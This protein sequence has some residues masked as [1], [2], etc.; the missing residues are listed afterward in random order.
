DN[1]PLVGF[2][3][4]LTPSSYRFALSLIQ[5]RPPIERL[6]P[7][8]FLMGEKVAKPDEGAAQIRT[9]TPSSVSVST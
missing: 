8:R 2:G 4:D 7:P 1:H 3:F 5:R 6:L 9:T